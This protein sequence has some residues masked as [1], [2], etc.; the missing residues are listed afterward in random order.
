MIDKI[1]WIYTKDKKIIFVTRKNRALV[2]VMRSIGHELTHHKQ[3]EDGKLKVK[4]PDIGGSIEDDAN[5]MAGKLIK[6]YSQIDDTIYD[7]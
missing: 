4:P 7:E 1:A 2:D 6:I 5:A 3:F